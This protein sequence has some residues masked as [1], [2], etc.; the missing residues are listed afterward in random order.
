MIH[1]NNGFGMINKAVSRDMAFQYFYAV[2]DNG[3]FYLSNNWAYSWEMHNT[4]IA[5]NLFALDVCENYPD[6]FVV[7]AGQGGT[8]LRS[9]DGGKTW[10]NDIIGTDNFNAVFYNHL[11]STFWIGGDNGS[12][13]YSIDSGNSWEE[14]T[15]GDNTANIVDF[16][17]T[18]TD[19]YLIAVKNDS[20]FIMRKTGASQFNAEQ[21]DTIPGVQLT[22]AFYLESM[23]QSAMYLAGNSTETMDGVVWKKDEVETVMQPPVDFF[24]GIEGFI[25]DIDGYEDIM[26]GSS[27]IWVTTDNGHIWEFSQ[28][29]S[30]WKLIYSD[31]YNRNLSSIVVNHGESSGFDCGRIIGMDG[32]VLKYGFEL[33]NYYPDNN[34]Q[35]DS[36]GMEIALKF[37]AIP[38][39]NSIQ[40]GVFIQSSI[41]GGIPFTAKYDEMDSSL[42]FLEN[43]RP[44]GG[45]T[46]PGEKWNISL[47]AAIAE[48]GDTAPEPFWGFN[49]DIDFMPPKSPGFNFNPVYSSVPINSQTSNF[50][51]GLFNDDDGFDLI[52]FSFDSLSL[53]CYGVDE[54]GNFNSYQKVNL[55]LSPF[56]KFEPEI[57]N[58]L[59]LSDVNCDSKP[60]LILYDRENIYLIKNGSIDFNFNFLEDPA[61]YFDGTGI[62]QVLPYNADDNG[63]VDLLILNDSLYTRMNIDEASFGEYPVGEE[64]SVPWEKMQCGDIDADGRQDFVLLD[65]SGSLMIR[66]GTGYG[67]FGDEFVVGGSYV[68]VRLA[69]INNDRMLE[70]IARD[71]VK[72]D[73]WSFDFTQWSFNNS[74][75]PALTQN[76]EQIINDFIIH[77]FGEYNSGFESYMD[78]AVITADGQVKI[79][80]NGTTMPEAPIFSEC[81]ADQQSISFPPEGLLQ[82]D[83]NKDAI[84]DLIVFNKNIGQFEAFIK[85]ALDW[86]PKFFL[87]VTVMKDSVAL[88]WT[89]F[90]DEMGES[91]QYY[92]LVRDTVPEFSTSS[93]SY[94][95]YDKMDTVFVDHGVEPY[96]SYWYAVQAVYG[97]D[98]FTKWS[99]TIHVDMFYELNGNQQGVLDD[100][101]RIYLAK[102]QLQVPNGESLVIQPGVEI[103]FMPGTGLDVFG[104]LEVQGG[105]MEQMVSFHGCHYEEQSWNGIVLHAS[106]D[107]VRFQ[108]FSISGAFKGIES[109]SRPLLM[110]FGGFNFNQTALE[111]QGDSLSLEHVIID[112]NLVGLSIGDGANANI[113]N[114]NILHGMQNSLTVAGV[115]Q[116]N[117]R[118]AIIWDNLGPVLKTNSTAQLSVSYSTVDSLQGMIV[119][120]DISKQPPVFMPPDS[121]YYRVDFSSPTI[122]AGDPKDDYSLEPIPNG[123][124]INQGIFGGSWF[125][126]PSFRPAL[127][128]NHHQ[129]FAQAKPGLSDTTQLVIKNAGA[130]DLAISD[131]EFLRQIPQFELLSQTIFT[132]EPY[133][134][135]IINIVFKP[136]TSIEY[137]DTLII[138]SNDP[139]YADD[140]FLVPVQGTGLSLNLINLIINP[141]QVAAQAKPGFSDTTQLDIRNAGLEDIEISDIKL[142]RQIPQFE[143]LSD[144][145]YTLESGVSVVINI[146]FKPNE[147]IVY[148]DTLVITCNDLEKVEK[149]IVPVQGTGLPPIAD[150]HPP[151]IVVTDKPGLIVF[152]AAVRFEFH[153]DDTSGVTT[154]DDESLITKHYRLIDIGS[155]QTIVKGDTAGINEVV[156]YPLKDGSY[157]FKLWASD[158]KGNV[159]D[160]SKADVVHFFTV[161]ASK[162]SV[163]SYRWYML[164]FPRLNTINWHDF[165]SDSAAMLLRW[166]NSKN[167]YIPLDNNEIPV[168]AGF[169]MFPVDSLS[170]DLNEYTQA[171]D[172]DS[173]YTSIQVGW[174]QIG[175]PVGYSVNWNDMK[176]IS[177]STDYK[178]M[179]IE[180]AVSNS[181]LENAVYWYQQTANYFGYNWTKL[182]TS[183]AI[184]WRGYWL[185]ANEEGTLV[186]STKP[187]FRQSVNSNVN[188]N[189]TMNLSKSGNDW[190]MNISLK[191]KNYADMKNIIGISNQARGSV[192]EPPH[193]GE[194]CSLFF[195][196]EKGQVTEKFEKDFEDHKDVRSWDVTIASRNDALE[197]TLSWQNDQLNPECIYVYL[198]D[199]QKEVI[200]DMN[201]QQDYTFKPEGGEYRFQVYAT[202]DASFTPEII[203][204]EY[205]L[206]QNYPNP[207]N[208]VT[209]IRFGVPQTADGKRVVLKIYDVLGREVVKLI[210]KT[211]KMG[212]HKIAWKGRNNSDKPAASG[213]YFYQLICG[214]ERLV[215]KMVL[216]R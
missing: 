186:F 42:V 158:T 214:K 91:F 164:S 87:P 156:L 211:M 21:G 133:D 171:S 98:V 72:I 14:A 29:K 110:K 183:Q 123:G 193:F 11:S 149:F 50:V 132:L 127:A 67:S 68:D 108:W 206:K 207:F 90:P 13:I 146:V 163:K 204:L 55:N 125:A 114:V 168:G 189:N 48:A 143:L 215:K 161:A 144:T 74:T 170:F 49:Y 196:T 28:E 76:D 93:F 44:H 141:S 138:S 64:I 191:N 27:A 85:K 119:A 41:S 47:S 176:F 19:L 152:Q 148:L 160:S 6:T 159:S 33:L 109:N 77:D 51:T 23:T 216:I 113:K 194:F 190:Q 71:S 88:T 104:S 126:T 118:N 150:D 212:Y 166:D 147:S 54:F 79:F 45:G 174:N 213:V 210:D 4:P 199:L 203:P 187:A 75:C 95:V 40:N 112:S 180:D 195:R 61:A 198:V 8:V 102:S 140:G 65:N 106:E 30:T 129:L 116:T 145:S 73:I 209:T 17:A 192:Y 10:V 153:A 185:K 70:I 103:V 59:I 101:T 78:I 105:A 172:D 36:M 25:T 107:T 121:G 117:V 122:D 53:Y 35:I 205:K 20:S 56:I 32:L 167:E 83:F 175:T 82:N 24:T 178:E 94:D 18:A 197:H 12:I 208:P 137:N 130:E 115:S 124:R 151:Q 86:R 26:Q 188:P 2:G 92:R 120:N 97:E 200:I 34:D 96:R 66:R 57:T 162:R 135:V 1:E 177:N 58:Q 81:S 184:P 139:N 136:D 100:T 39:L 43:N 5:S 154:G 134:S 84:L 169:W 201:N 52:T 128:V 111:F 69:D 99:D 60:D 7:A 142:S 182:D 179:S 16:V 3:N 37:S 80:E 46:I 165:Y 38:D 131:I 181:L 63:L 173:L 31:I 202:M 89:S 157:H 22:S 62:K 15:A 155:G 9:I